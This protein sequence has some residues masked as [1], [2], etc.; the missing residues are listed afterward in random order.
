MNA[1]EKLFNEKKTEN[2][3]ISYKSTGNNLLDILFMTNYF[4]KHLDEVRIGDSSKEQMFARFIR[5]P[6]FGLGR[7]DLGRKLMKL[8][9]V[10]PQDIVKSGRYDDLIY[11]GTAPALE[12]LKSE[13]L[14][15]NHLAKKWCPRFTKKNTK[16]ATALAK[17][18][19]MSYKEYRKA[20]KCEDTIEYKLSYAELNEEVN[21]L[22]ELFNKGKYNHPLVESIEFDKIPS[23][24]MLKYYGAFKRREDTKERFEAYLESVRKG[25]KKLNVST[26]NVYDI[27][28]NRNMIDATLFFDKLEKI[29]ISC[30]PIIDTSASMSWTSSDDAYGKA[31][32]IGHYL[33][34]CSTY[35]NG[36]A[37]PFSSTPRLMKITGNTYNEE[38]RSLHT[39][40]C[41]RTNFGAVMNLL[42]DLKELPE[43]L[44]VLSDMEF[45]QGSSTSKN[46]LQRIWK[47][48]GYTTKIIWWNFNA[49]N[50]TVPETDEMGNIYLSGYSP[51][52]LKYLEAGFDGEKFLDKLLKEY[53]NNIK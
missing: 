16:F 10:E 34:K 21:P 3:D 37:I 13:V 23:L 9:M 36:Y 53:E 7:R 4:E 46:E 41:S 35:C 39:G 45:D 25:E 2:G 47:E 30:I 15:G 24:A 12:L 17:I 11:K 38:I 49:R 19:G 33:A 50:K 6:R 43:Y 32:S 29:E 40:D 27:Y 51:M 28:K 22:E 26:T 42:K 48:N 14:K 31:M 20:I 8:A 1:I 18:W 52:L 5:D 44:V